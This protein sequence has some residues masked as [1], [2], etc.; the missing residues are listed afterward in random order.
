MQHKSDDTPI[1][2]KSCCNIVFLKLHSDF[3][4]LSLKGVRIKLMKEIRKVVVHEAAMDEI[5]G[6][7]Q[8]NNLRPGDKLP[9]EREIV[10]LLK[11]S[12]STVRAA[13]S[14]LEINNVI[15]IKHGSGIFVSSLEGV[16]L[17]KYTSSR[18]S[19]ENFK[20]V[21]HVAQARIML[22]TFCAVE[23]SK[24]ITQEQLQ[25]LYEHEERENNL[26]SNGE[27]DSECYIYPNLALERLISSF[28]NN[29][30]LHDFHRAIEETW[31]KAFSNINAVPL[32]VSVRHKDHLEIIKA[33][34]AGSETRIKKAVKAHLISTISSIDKILL[35][36]VK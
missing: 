24:T 17:S 19:K 14:A 35:D 8:E 5:L 3:D 33:I 13:L 1:G 7:I 23:V 6:Y 4:W 11:V 29:P 15:T 34:E 21:K 9:P 27:P 26:L 36:E 16:L 28:L 25:L 22:E 18:D 10:K 2:C 32:S 20:L 31:R 30:L 12:R